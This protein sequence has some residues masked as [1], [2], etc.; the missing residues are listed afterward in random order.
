MINDILWDGWRPVKTP[1]TSVINDMFPTAVVVKTALGAKE[2]Q[3][4]RKVQLQQAK[5]KL[6]QTKAICKRHLINDFK[7][8]A[9]AQN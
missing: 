6:K 9:H 7:Q 3:E 4:L 5:E 2:V 8:N 1:I